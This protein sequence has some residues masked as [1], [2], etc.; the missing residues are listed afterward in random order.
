MIAGTD[1][2][3]QYFLPAGA[4]VGIEEGVE[5][6]VGNVVASIPQEPSKTRDII[7]CLPRVADLFEARIPREFT[8]MAERTGAIGFGKETKG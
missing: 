6:K 3:A 2:P 1:I 8:I 4:I 7:G 5:V